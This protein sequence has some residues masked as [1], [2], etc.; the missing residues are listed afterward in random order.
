MTVLNKIHGQT[1]RHAAFP[2]QITSV[3]SPSPQHSAVLSSFTAGTG[4]TAQIM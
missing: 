1:D 3:N 2:P 4:L